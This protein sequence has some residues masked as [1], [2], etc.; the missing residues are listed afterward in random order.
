ML[1]HLLQGDHLL[2]YL[3]G[4]Y[5]RCRR[6]RENSI[7]LGSDM[8]GVYF[9]SDG[10]LLFG[11]EIHAGAH[12]GRCLGKH[13]RHPSVQRSPGMVGFGGH[14]HGQNNFFLRYFPVLYAEK[15]HNGSLEVPEIGNI[16]PLF[17]A[18]ADY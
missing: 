5:T 2:Q 11:I 16:F 8:I 10:K 9:K 6:C 14:R 12:G 18:F 4:E 13:D 3:H 15:L 7:S 17:N 1:N